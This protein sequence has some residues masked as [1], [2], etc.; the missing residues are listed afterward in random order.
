MH[1]EM[2]GREGSLFKWD[3]IFIE[4]HQF[5]QAASFTCQKWAISNIISCH[6]WELH[7]WTWRQ[8][9]TFHF[10]PL[11]FLCLFSA[12]NRCH[13]K[14]RRSWFLTT[15]L[16]CSSVKRKKHVM[17]K[18]PLCNMNWK[19]LM[20][21]WL[22][23][24]GLKPIFL[25]WNCNQYLTCMF[26]AYFFMLMLCL[27]SFMMSK[28]WHHQWYHMWHQGKSAKIMRY[29]QADFFSSKETYK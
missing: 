3:F 21:L 26:W 25:D 29:T 18:A 8:P 6:R 2:L 4:Q 1:M 12:R 24:Q 22:V 11:I 9:S 13:D 14:C 17:K 5:P 10:I 28:T 15:E 23:F 20:S 16:I 7:R 27:D 19:D